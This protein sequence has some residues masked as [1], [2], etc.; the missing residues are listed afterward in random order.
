MSLKSGQKVSA[1]LKKRALSGSFC[2]K[3]EQRVSELNISEK[4]H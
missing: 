3:S 1:K 2:C 4:K